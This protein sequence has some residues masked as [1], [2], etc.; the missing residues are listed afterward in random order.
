MIDQGARLRA[1]HR[2]LGHERATTTLDTYA[3]LW[4]RLGGHNAS[5]SRCRAVA[6][7]VRSASCASVG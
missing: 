6:D 2:R 1:V 5:C 3:H 7:C 4:A